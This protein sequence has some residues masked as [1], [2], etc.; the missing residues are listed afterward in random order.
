MLD[1]YYVFSKISCDQ[2]FVKLLNSPYHV[3]IQLIK[4]QFYK[5]DALYCPRNI[6]S[7]HIS[8]YIC[9]QQTVQ[10]G[11]YCEECFYVI[12]IKHCDTTVST[13][14]FRIVSHSLKGEKLLLNILKIGFVQ[15]KVVFRQEKIDMYKSYDTPLACT[16]KMMIKFLHI[17]YYTHE[18]T[19]SS[20]CGCLQY[21]CVSVL[22]T[23][24]NKFTFIGRIIQSFVAMLRLP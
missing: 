13:I 18:L 17:P 2:H 9:M 8:I 16:K 14:L 24:Q 5:N 23:Y 20:L 1:T 10:M 19:M 15:I 12:T 7:T 6:H 21:I 4:P 11:D 3:H 22:S